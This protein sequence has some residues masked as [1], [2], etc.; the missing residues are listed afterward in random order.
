M[1]S[2]SLR[3]STAAWMRANAS[4]RDTTALPLVWPQRLGHVWSSIITPAA[5]AR[6]KLEGVVSMRLEG[7][8]E[9]EVSRGKNGRRE[10]LG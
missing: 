3:A 2:P 9:C 4:P 6:A 10:G 1:S 8:K 7:R 5:P